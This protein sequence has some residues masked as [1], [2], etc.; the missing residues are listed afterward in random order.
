MLLSIQSCETVDQLN[1]L[2]TANPAYQQSLNADFT[3]RKQQILLANPISNHPK[4]HSNV[5]F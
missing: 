5:D 2:F 4:A 1:Q 3:K